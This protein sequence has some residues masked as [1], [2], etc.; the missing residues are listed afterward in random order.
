M[1]TI[2]VERAVKDVGECFECEN[3]IMIG[4]K[5][6]KFL[7]QLIHQKCLISRE[8]NDMYTAKNGVCPKCHLELPPSKECCE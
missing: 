7:G 6:L 2:Y 5:Y 1:S 8:I 3:P 4:D